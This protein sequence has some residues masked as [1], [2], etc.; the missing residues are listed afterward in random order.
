MIFS[1][2]GP[3]FASGVEC[4]VKL[5]FHSQLGRWSKDP[6]S[7]DKNSIRFF[8]TE[9]SHGPGPGNLDITGS[10]LPDEQDP[11]ATRTCALQHLLDQFLPQDA[12]RRI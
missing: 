9:L 2:F 7:L 11:S 8:V 1:K 5:L 12:L 6:E 4:P 10:P 3:S